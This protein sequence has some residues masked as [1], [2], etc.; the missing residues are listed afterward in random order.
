MKDFVKR[1]KAAGRKE[2]CDGC[3]VELDTYE[4]TK[5]ARQRLGELVKALP[6]P[7]TGRSRF[8]P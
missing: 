8:S 7:S 5:D 6:A 4:L 3:H 2:T 1:A